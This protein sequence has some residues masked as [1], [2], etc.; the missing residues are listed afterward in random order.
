M[1]LSTRAMEILQEA[2]ERAGGS[3]FLFPGVSTVPHGFRASFR[4]W[5]SAHGAV[6]REVAE[7]A[8][9]HKE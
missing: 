5:A 9:A 1:P 6:P 7:V 8:L 4:T 3:A 2:R